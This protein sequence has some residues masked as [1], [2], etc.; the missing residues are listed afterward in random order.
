MIRKLI[1]LSPSTAVVSLPAQWVQQNQLQKG[2]PLSM[3]VEENTLIIS[4]Q[5]KPRFTEKTID[6][7]ALSERLTWITIDTAYIAGYDS[8]KILTKNKTQTAL[9]TKIVRYFPSMMIIEEEDTFVRFE[10]TEE[11]PQP[12]DIIIQRIF[13]ILLTIIEESIQNIQ[14]KN[15][16]T[17]AKVKK[18]DYILNS[19]ASY[20]QRSITKFGYKPFS[21]TGVMYALINT[22]ET[23]ADKLCLL[24]EEVSQSQ[25][26]LPSIQHLEKLQA[27]VSDLRHM[28]FKYSDSKLSQLEQDITQ[29]GSESHNYAAKFRDIK[30]L[31]R[32][33]MEL[34]MQLH[35]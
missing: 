29:L 5:N 23:V 25:K 35:Y 19:Y 9:M 33:C 17:L 20:A 12:L 1:Q 3:Q 15:W 11:V 34:E 21:K 31:L 22:I 30:D 6:V 32:N 10:S 27:L 14:T 2:M 16:E 18:R 28:H 4:T 24:F 7:S 26:N 8:L 13:N